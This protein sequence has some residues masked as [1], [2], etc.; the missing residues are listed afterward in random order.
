MPI[1]KAIQV[2]AMVNVYDEDD[3]LI[4][5]K[6]GELVEFDSKSVKIRNKDP[7]RAA[8]FEIYDDKGY[9]LT[10]SK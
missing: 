2:P 10:F 1:K 6:Q 3:I 5:S 4:I 8:D 7:N 9:L